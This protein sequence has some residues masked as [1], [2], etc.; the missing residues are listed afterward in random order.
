MLSTNTNIDFFIELAKLPS[1]VVVLI[2]DCLPKCI[3]PE[4]LYFPPIRRIVASAILSDVHI[5]KNVRRHKKRFSMGIGY[6][7]CD[8]KQLEIEFGNLK[9]GIAQYGIYPK[10]MYIQD[11]EQFEAILDALPEL[12]MA[13]LSINGRFHMK[14]LLDSNAFLKL[15]LNSKVK[16]DFLQLISFQSIDKFPPVATSIRLIDHELSSYEIPGVKKLSI[17]YG[18][19]EIEKYTFSSDLEDLEI[20]TYGM[21]PIIFPQN[22]RKLR[23]CLH[24]PDGNFISQELVSLEYLLLCLPEFESFEEIGIIAPNLKTLELEWCTQMADFD[25]LQQYQK[26][27]RLVLENCDYPVT[28]LNECPFPELEIFEYAVDSFSISGDVDSLNFT[29]PSNLKC[30]SIKYSGSEVVE[31]STSVLRTALT[32]LHVSNLSITDKYL[33]LN[34]NLQYVHINTSNLAFESSFRIPYMTE[35]LTLEADYITFE[36]LDFIHNLLNRLVQLHLI[37]KKQGKLCPITRK[38]EWPLVLGDFEL[39]G[40]SIDYQT[41]KFMNL[42]ESKLEKINIRG[43][44]IK[45]FDIDL[46]PVSVK[47]LTLLYMGI[48]E[49]PE[50]FEKFEK[51]Y[52]LSL[53]GNQLRKVKPVKLPVTSLNIL[54]LSHCHLRLLSPF[55]VSMFEEQNRNAEINVYALA[56]SK[57]NVLEARRVMKVIKG[58]S[59]MLSGSDETLREISKHSS[60]LKYRFILVNP[61]FKESEFSGTKE[62]V[63]RYDS[64]DLYNGSEFGLDD[65]EDAGDNKRVKLASS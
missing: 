16:F 4:L 14:G 17:D 56:N 12:L 28:L 64:D 11:T 20:N 61:N 38:I 62:A 3:L 43:G 19:E 37:A 40:F 42:N 10:T 5:T 6:L 60:R 52:H 33:H 51:L 30:L 21:I 2:I 46:F 9:Q 35:K 44:G 54:N 7:I 32:H 27:K 57:V 39:K 63:N 31:F 23:I 53:Q 13:A 41:L 55:L 1:E 29:F 25:S 47:D 36:S 15:L 22:L 24:S 34:E 26:L 45:T 48:R 65:E 50:S 8:C 49:L 18:S 58:L 59:L